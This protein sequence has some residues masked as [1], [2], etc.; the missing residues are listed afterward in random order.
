MGYNAGGTFFENHRS[1]GFDTVANDV[2]C[3]VELRRSKRQAGGMMPT[4]VGMEIGVDTVLMQSTRACREYYTR[5][6]QLIP[7]NAFS[8]SVLPC[9][10]TLNQ[11]TNDERFKID[12]KFR[13]TTRNSCYLQR[14]AVSGTSIFSKIMYGQQCC[15]DSNG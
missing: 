7:T 1:S 9:P 15:C 10:C 3:V 12:S 14:F 8:N 4:S 2:S 6:I 11:A 5:D 13:I